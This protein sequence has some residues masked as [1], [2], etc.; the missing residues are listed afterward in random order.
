VQRQ[1][2]PQARLDPTLLQA[3]QDQNPLAMQA[4]A[5]LLDNSFMQALMSADPREKWLP[6]GSHGDREAEREIGREEEIIEDD[7]ARRAG[8]KEPPQDGS[9]EHGQLDPTAVDHANHAFW[10]SVAVAAEGMGLVNAAR[11]MH[12]YL[13][14]TGSL[15]TI[16]PAL[17]LREA[18]SVQEELAYHQ[19]RLTH[20]VLQILEEA[21]PE[22]EL[23]IPV[24]SP[25]QSQDTFAIS[26][27]D[28]S[29]WFF[30]MAGHWARMDGS[31]DFV[32]DR[33]EPGWGTLYFEVVFS[34]GD[35]YNW[36]KGKSVTI[37][38]IT[39]DDSVAG[40]LHKVGLAHEY[41]VLGTMP[42]SFDMKYFGPHVTPNIPDHEPAP[43]RDGSRVDPDRE[44]A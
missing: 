22:E 33:Q 35:D 4:T 8:P 2:A 40:R 31:C 5:G 16:D 7:L 32:P 42:M 9:G 29:D 27:E 10:R 43:D 17:V 38:G 39:V 34:L 1:Y 23:T 24:A 44:R 41:E 21:N 28:S 30:A 18:E 6:E 36:D 15:L 19:G 26:E 11:G 25:K 3:L 12:H 13:D 20:Q 37:G 14:N